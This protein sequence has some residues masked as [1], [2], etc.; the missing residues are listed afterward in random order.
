MIL[1]IFNNCPRC[2]YSLRGLLDN[3]TCPE[4]GLRFDERCVRYRVTNPS[5]ILVFGLIM[6]AGGCVSVKH[7]PH[8]V[9]LANASAWE[10]VGAIAGAL[11]IACATAGVWFVVKRYRRGLEVAITGDG[12]ILRLP[13]FND[14]LVPWSDIGSASIKERP[15]G[16]PQVASVY[17]ASQKKTVEV[18]RMANVFPRRADVEHFV[19][20]VNDRVYSPPD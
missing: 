19:A 2:R 7:L 5:Q 16:K 17:I 4:C 11:W 20:E 9:D 13:G 6:L 10:T 14:D 12:L 18:G 3:R 15:V 8:F 1:S